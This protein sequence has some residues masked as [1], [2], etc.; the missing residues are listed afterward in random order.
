MFVRVIRKGLE[1]FLASCIVSG[2]ELTSRQ[3]S[4]IPAYFRQ[5]FKWQIK[6]WFLFGTVITQPAMW[7]VVLYICMD[8]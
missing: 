2:N 1:T 4:T 7:G 5:H 6:N 3:L 8:I